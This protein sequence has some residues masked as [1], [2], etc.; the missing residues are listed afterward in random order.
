MLVSGSL[1][2]RER[3]SVEVSPLDNP[4]RPTLDRRNGPGGE[5]PSS[6]LALDVVFEMVASK[7]GDFDVARGREKSVEV[8]PQLLARAMLSQPLVEDL[9]ASRALF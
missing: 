7:V 6:G 9:H 4:V 2:V 8:V 1:D 3:V 5:R